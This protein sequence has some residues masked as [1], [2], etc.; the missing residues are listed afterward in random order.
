[1]GV[2]D[3]NF[4][5]IQINNTFLKMLGISKHETLGKKC[6][7]VFPSSLC[8]ADNCPL[9]RIFKGDDHIEGGM[10]IECKDGGTLPCLLTAAPFRSP[11]GTLIGIIEN[12]RCLSNIE[13]GEDVI[14]KQ[15]HI[16]E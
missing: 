14:Q 1:M 15:I 12:F 10:E 4:N 11:N 9:N 5:L 3:K 2:I 6:Y 16:L 7:E 13:H 8:H